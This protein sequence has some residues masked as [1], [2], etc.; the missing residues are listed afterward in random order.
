MNMS[1]STTWRRTGFHAP[2]WLHAG[3]LLF[4]FAGF[5]ILRGVLQGQGLGGAFGHLP[6]LLFSALPVLAGI[7]VGMSETRLGLARNVVLLLMVTATLMTMIDLTAPTASLPPLLFPTWEAGFVAE[8]A[9][10]RSTF[11]GRAIPT[12]I[13]WIVDRGRGSGEV[14]QRYPIGHPRLMIANGFFAFLFFLM[15]FGIVG[16]VLG[17]MT[18]VRRRVVFPRARDERLARVFLAWSLAPTL[19]WAVVGFSRQAQAAVLFRGEPFFLVLLPALPLLFL[20]VGG[21]RATNK[22]ERDIHLGGD[23]PGGEG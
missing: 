7:A 17:F 23:P 16:T 20:A 22:A 21:W 19:Y 13:S 4:V 3:L 14:L 11:E 2:L 12:L 8:A 10:G 18:W 1:G 5:Y 6:G 9:A 15:P